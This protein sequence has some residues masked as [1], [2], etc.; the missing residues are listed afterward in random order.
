MGSKG[1]EVKMTPPHPGDFIRTEIVQELGLSVDEVAQIL[2]VDSTVLSEV[3]SCQSSLS[4]ELAL[5]IEKAFGVG[6]DMLLRM[7]A[8]YDASQMRAR[9]HE[10]RVERYAPLSR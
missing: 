6:M 5:R 4:P 9:E 10:I 1:I 2:G 8:W 7:Q 3:L